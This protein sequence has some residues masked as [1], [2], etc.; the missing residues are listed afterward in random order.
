MTARK[1]NLA[2]AVSKLNQPHK[3]T[4]TQP[5]SRSG[6]KTVAGYFDPEMSKRLKILAV[7][8]DRTLQDLLGEALQDLFKK[9]D[10]GR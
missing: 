3:I 1:T 9:Y 6:L 8:Q 7:E 10:K 2:E 5:R 4:P